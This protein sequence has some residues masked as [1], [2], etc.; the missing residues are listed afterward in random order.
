[1]NDDFRSA[2]RDR[3]LEVMER[4][5]AGAVVLRLAE[6]FAWYTGGGNSRVE[7]ASPVGV[8]DGVLTPAGERPRTRDEEATDFEVVE[9]V[10][11]QGPGGSP[12]TP[13][14]R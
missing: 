12:A 6:N 7:Y 1:M 14:E 9:Y 2:R 8:A 5:G 4:A 10:W 13:R 11:E 3:L